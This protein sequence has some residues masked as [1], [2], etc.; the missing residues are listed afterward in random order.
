MQEVYSLARV[1]NLNRK[2]IE[3]G[4]DPSWDF[5]LPRMIENYPTSTFLGAVLVLCGCCFCIWSVIGFKLK[6]LEI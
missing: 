5:F 6:E 2:T 1:Y 3:R 4:L